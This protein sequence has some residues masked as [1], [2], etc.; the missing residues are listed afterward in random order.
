[1]IDTLPIIDLPKGGAWVNL[2]TASGISLGASVSIQ[3]LSA[4]DVNYSISAAE[5]GGDPLPYEI[6]TKGQ[7]ET[8][9]QGA[10]GLWAR[11]VSGGSVSVQEKAE[12]VPFPLS[13]FG[14]ISVAENTPRVQMA[15]N[16]GIVDKAFVL[17]TGTATVV[18]EDSLFK[19]TVNAAGET[20]AA[21][22]KHQI[23]Y[24]PGQGAINPYTAIFAPATPG[25]EQVAGFISAT[26]GFGFGYN[27]DGE[28]GVLHSHDGKTEIQELTVTTP[29][30]GAENATVTINDTPYTVPLTVGTIEHNA[31]EIAASLL[32]QV[33]A[34]DF[35]SNGAQ[36]VAASQISAVQGA[37]AF[38]SS[39]A[40]AAWSQVEAGVA[41]TNDWTA[42]A[43]WNQYVPPDLNPQKGNVYKIQFQFL[44]FG[45][46]EYYVE[47]PKTAQF[48]L[49]HRIEYPNKNILPS[50]TNPTFRLGWAITNLTN[51]T[52]LTISGA[53]T[54]GFIEGKIVLTEDPIT[55]E[56][57]TATLAQTKTALLTIRNRTILNEQRNR[58]ELFQLKVA[59]STDSSKGAIVE[60][61]KF[62]DLPDPDIQF[63]Y[64]DKDKSITEVSY[65]QY[66][67]T[68]GRIID[69]ETVSING[70]RIDL[71]AQEAH[72]L[73]GEY[74]VVAMRQNGTPAEP[75]R[76]LLVQREDL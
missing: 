23:T 40:V 39:T 60:V 31:R 65:D 54:A 62:S 26:D 52:P 43:D 12:E 19:A 44:G 20:A 15:A 30:V 3:S 18:A 64:F 37:F 11:S 9:L 16:Y 68:G 53:S 58:A 70:G 75:A 33:P 6:L 46:I 63:E 29:A 49:V 76:A 14:E 48:D 72:L 10:A 55:V 7:R 22:S 36:V 24:R 27:P 57:T 41:V 66:A 74:L 71:A 67:V 47:N 56:G 69:A 51:S 42:I 73:P 4:A 25:S 34:Y 38:S 59:A 2:Y 45:G 61:L 8:I 17:K 50:V 32:A 13:A 21:L 5:P 1:M 28:F 35:T